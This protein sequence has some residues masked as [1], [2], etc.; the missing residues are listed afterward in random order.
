MIGCKKD[1]FNALMI[2]NIPLLKQ[3]DRGAMYD[4]GELKFIWT[5]QGAT[6]ANHI[7]EDTEEILYLVRGEVELTL[8]EEI[9]HVTAPAKITIPPNTYHKL[10]M[11]TETEILEKRSF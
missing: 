5:R 10:L 6:R 4:C 11:L 9:S 1:L 2:E 8:G 7:H 3:D